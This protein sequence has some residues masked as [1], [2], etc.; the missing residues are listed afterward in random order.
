MVQI[1]DVQRLLIKFSD[2]FS[3]TCIIRNDNDWTLYVDT[4]NKIERWTRDNNLILNA[5]KTQELVF[6]NP[7]VK[8]QTI[9]EL[10]DR[11]LT[12]N[13]VSICPSDSVKY[14]GLTIDSKFR[15]SE[16]IDNVYK[17]CF[18]VSHYAIKLLRRCSS[19]SVIRDF[20]D[21]CILPFI[22]YAISCFI[23]FIHR[24]DWLM[25]RR[26]LRRLACITGRNKND[27]TIMILNR[28]E[29]MVRTFAIKFMP[30]IKAVNYNLRTKMSH[31]RYNKV[32][33]QKLTSYVVY[34][35]PS[36]FSDIYTL[37]SS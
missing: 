15:F 1:E 36:F 16:H 25:L 20:V 13:N 7:N 29:K 27:Y 23:G 10:S 2:H 4:V 5:S 28:L 35:K 26:I 17:K 34:F 8:N 33:S 30:E 19:L 9:L 18:S 12:I 6:L 3:L 24:D 32:L 11:K 22:Y 21:V 31:T 14:L 37:L